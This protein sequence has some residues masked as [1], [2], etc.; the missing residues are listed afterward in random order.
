MH[1]LLN[2]RRL[3]GQ[4]WFYACFWCFCCFL[5]SP[6]RSEGGKDEWELLCSTSEEWEELT[7]SFRGSKQSYER[8]LFK[9]LNDDLLPDILQM[10]T[11][12]VCIVYFC[13]LKPS[14][15]WNILCISIVFNVYGLDV[16]VEL[17]GVSKYWCISLHYIRNN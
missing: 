9:V 1:V 10:I 7:E 16:L 11:A 15:Y 8:S 6:I 3:D 13:I 4:D 2:L 14:K 5:Y 17:L 12:K